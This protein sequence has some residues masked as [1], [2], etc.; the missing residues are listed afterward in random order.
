MDFTKKGKRKSQVD[1]VDDEDFL[2]PPRK[3]GMK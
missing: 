3:R 2:A 1:D